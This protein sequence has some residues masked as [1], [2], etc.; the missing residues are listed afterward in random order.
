[1][2]ELR[3]KSEWPK[4]K[5]C[6]ACQRNLRVGNFVRR[7]IETK[8]GLPRWQSWCKECK[9]GAEYARV[10]NGNRQLSS[11]NYPN[12]AFA[13]KI[14]DNALVTKLLRW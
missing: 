8:D 7:H 6:S 11:G 13:P 10:G 5:K 12:A 2:A 9:N 4:T 1:M 14:E 3:P